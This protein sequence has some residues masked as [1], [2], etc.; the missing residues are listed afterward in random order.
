VTALSILLDLS[1]H[2]ISV[3]WCACVYIELVLCG[4]TAFFPFVLH[5]PTQKEKNGQPHKTNIELCGCMYVCIM[6]CFDCC[7]AC[8]CM[9]VCVCVCVCAFMRRLCAV[10]WILLNKVTK[11]GIQHST[12]LVMN[13]CYADNNGHVVHIPYQHCIANVLQQCTSTM[14]I[15]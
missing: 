12:K 3:G 14:E 11:S 2:L 9:W 4:Q 10:W 15:Y 8:V 6:L 13:Y 5:N 7:Y 1:L